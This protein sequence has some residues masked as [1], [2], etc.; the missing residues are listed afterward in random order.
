MT[1]LCLGCEAV[2][3]KLHNYGYMLHI[4]LNMHI[5]TPLS[6]SSVAT[7]V[8]HPQPTLTSTGVDTEGLSCLFT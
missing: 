7:T 6:T 1:G 8:D 5:D 4:F 3:L 2:E